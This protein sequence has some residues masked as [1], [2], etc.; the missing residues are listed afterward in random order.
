MP[1]IFLLLFNYQ[2]FIFFLGGLKLG[3]NLYMP[4]IKTV[5]SIP[6]EVQANEEL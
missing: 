6:T 2:F 4:L 5:E 3:K 1:V